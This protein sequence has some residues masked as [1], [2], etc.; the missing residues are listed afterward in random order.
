MLEDKLQTFAEEQSSFY[1]YGERAIALHKQTEN[2]INDFLQLLEISTR[3]ND[4]LKQKKMFSN[5][6]NVISI[7]NCFNL[8][9]NDKLITE[10]TA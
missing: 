4:N 1:I 10:L 9:P 2:L 7:D 8:Y 3:N 5:A 6:I